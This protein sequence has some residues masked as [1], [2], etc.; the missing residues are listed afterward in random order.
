[1]RKIDNKIEAAFIE[2]F[3]LGEKTELVHEVLDS[4]FYSFLKEQFE[5]NTINQ[6]EMI[7][8]IYTYFYLQRIVTLAEQYPSILKYKSHENN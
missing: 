5:F 7:D 2:L 4:F 1:M 3:D 8:F 6:F